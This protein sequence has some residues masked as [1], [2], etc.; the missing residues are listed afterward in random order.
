MKFKLIITSVAL[1]ITQTAFAAP[2][3]APASCPTVAAFSNVGVSS[4]MQDPQKG[5]WAGIEWKNKFNTNHEWTFG[6]GEFYSDNGDTNAV[7]TEANKA[8]PGLT[9]GSGP[10]KMNGPA[11]D[12]Y[13]CYYPGKRGIYGMAMTPPVSPQSMQ[14]AMLS[15]HR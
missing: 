1:L 3:Q 10:T 5:T 8:I 7:L 12:V 13:V 4:A 2:S 14:K 11:G 6:I 15:Q 9:Y